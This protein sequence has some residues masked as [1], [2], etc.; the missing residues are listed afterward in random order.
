MVERGELG[1]EEAHIMSVR[2]RSE[3]NMLGIVWC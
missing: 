1:V 2:Q 3:E